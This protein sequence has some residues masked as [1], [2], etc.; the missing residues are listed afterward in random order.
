MLY[1]NLDDGL[2]F[3]Y[4]VLIGYNSKN[5]SFLFTTLAHY[6]N[7]SQFEEFC[8]KMR[9]APLTEEAKEENPNLILHFSEDYIKNLLDVS[10]LIP[11]ENIKFQWELETILQVLSKLN[12]S[13]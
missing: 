2:S 12:Y 9:V 7:E 3:A 8:K 1:K 5:S 13:E 11:I 4:D 10:N 6:L